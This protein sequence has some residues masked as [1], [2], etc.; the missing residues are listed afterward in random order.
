[1]LRQFLKSLLIKVYLLWVKLRVMLLGK[2]A[3]V[4][5]LARCDRRLVQALLSAYGARLGRGINFKG[6]LL[7]DN[8]YE[9]QDSTRDLSRLRIGN[10]CVIGRGVFFDLV[11]EIILEDEVG[12]GAYSMLMTHMDLG[13]MPM[14][15][16][17]PRKTAPIRIGAGTFT[18]AH[19]VILQGVVLGKC[20]IVAA[21]SVVTQSFPDYSLV[22]GVPAR[23]IRSLDPEQPKD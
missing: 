12:I 6:N 8:V 10:G 22:A 2:E 17:Y 3:L 16:T 11:D 14:A 5:A 1:M 13:K 7:M 4:R 21:G 23:L 19:V 20:C 9:D 18:G 15:R